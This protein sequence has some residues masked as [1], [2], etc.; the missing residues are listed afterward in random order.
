MI[1]RSGALAAGTVDGGCDHAGHH[2][3][4]GSIAG[5]RVVQQGAAVRPQQHRSP[6]PYIENL[7]VQRS[8]VRALG[9]R[10]KERCQQEDPQPAAGYAAGQQQQERAQQRQ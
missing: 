3:P 7:H 10:K 4:A 8:G 6:L 1:T 5:A 9:P 2:I